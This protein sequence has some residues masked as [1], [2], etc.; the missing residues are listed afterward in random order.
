VLQLVLAKQPVPPVLHSLPVAYEAPLINKRN[1][2]IRGMKLNIT[3]LQSNMANTRMA[4]TR[5]EV[6]ALQLTASTIDR[7]LSVQ[8][9]PLCPP[10]SIL[11]RTVVDKR[12]YP[13]ICKM[14]LDSSSAP[15]LSPAL[16]LPSSQL[17]WTRLVMP[18]AARS[19]SC[20]GTAGFGKCPCQS[21]PKSFHHS[22]ERV[23]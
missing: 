16:Q 17:P 3:R 4:S 1:I 11:C 12:G 9:P 14:L 22:C 18:H 10:S 13:A 2:A 5:L 19:C 20:S 15:Q 7:D 23:K 8:S 6:L 21:R